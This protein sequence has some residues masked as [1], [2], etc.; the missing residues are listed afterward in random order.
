MLCPRRSPRP[1]AAPRD[2]RPSS[3]D[4]SSRVQWSPSPPTV[5][6]SESSPASPA[7]TEAPWGAASWPLEGPPALNTV[8]A[9]PLPCWGSFSLCPQTF[10]SPWTNVPASKSGGWVQLCRSYPLYLSLSPSFSPFLFIVF[11]L[12]TFPLLFPFTLALKIFQ[13]TFNRICFSM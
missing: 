10:L 4:A 12:V 5:W 2:A 13:G 6:L 7:C 8:V 11:I 3:T 9:K 1:H